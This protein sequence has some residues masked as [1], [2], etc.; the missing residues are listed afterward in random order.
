MDKQYCSKRQK[1]EAAKNNRNQTVQDGT[2]IFILARTCLDKTIYP[3]NPW[4]QRQYE[5]KRCSTGLEFPRKCIK[6]FKEQEGQ[7]PK[8][9]QI[10][11]Q[12]GFDISAKQ[13]LC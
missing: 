11:S 8:Y 13:I 3:E 5:N 6:N 1:C 2:Y 4:R 7:R 9:S 10:V 12:S